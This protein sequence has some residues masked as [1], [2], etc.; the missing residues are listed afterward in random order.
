[1]LSD[2]T[3]ILTVVYEPLLHGDPPL[4]EVLFIDE[5]PVHR[6]HYERA[7]LSVCYFSQESLANS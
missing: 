6:V 5:H 3:L 1:V 4:R 2:A 7:A